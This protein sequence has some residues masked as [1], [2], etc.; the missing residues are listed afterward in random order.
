MVDLTECEEALPALTAEEA[1]QLRV[2][3]F[4]WM[5]QTA[6][7]IMVY[8]E[9][10]AH[11][12]CMA[13]L[14][15]TRKLLKV[16]D[17]MALDCYRKKSGQPSTRREPCECQACGMSRQVRQLAVAELRARKDGDVSCLD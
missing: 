11:Q 16:S 14:R 9:E 2:C 4:C 3:R 12:E 10:F 6:V 17:E 8:G 13:T 1:E 15:I 7:F 5:P